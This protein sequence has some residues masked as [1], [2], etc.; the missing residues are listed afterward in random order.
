MDKWDWEWDLGQNATWCLDNIFDKVLQ[1]MDKFRTNL[2]VY[3]L[4]LF[5]MMFEMISFMSSNIISKKL[6]YG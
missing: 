5:E 4:P 3:I 6:R 2:G 1:Y